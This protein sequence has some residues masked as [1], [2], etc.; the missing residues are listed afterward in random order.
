M[1]IEKPI[2]S[3]L[4]VGLLI[5]SLSV[6]KYVHDLTTWAQANG[7]TI[8]VTHLIVHA[9]VVTDT[10]A[11]RR[12]VF[13]MKR[14]GV[15]AA[16]FQSLASL[17]YKIVVRLEQLRLKQNSRYSNHMQMFDLSELVPTTIR[18]VPQV[19]KSG[20]VYRFSSADVGQVRKLGLDLLV[21]CGSGILRGDILKAARLGILSFHHA[22]NRINRGGPPGFWEVYFQ[23]DTTGFT[24]QQLTEELD[25]G[26][27]LMRGHFA[28]QPYYLLN[29]A[30]LFEK[31]NYYLT[32]LLKKIACNGALP[33][34]LESV[35]YSNVLLRLPRVNQS[36][37][38]IFKTCYHL[39]TK[40]LRQAL[41]V[42]RRWNV[43]Y[44]RSDW[45]DAVLS[46]GVK[47]K[48]L[49]N[50]FLADPFVMTMSGRD[51]C[52]VEDYEG[53]KGR[54][55]IAVYELGREGDVRVGTA[56]EE[57]FHLSFPFLFEYHGNI[58]MC[59]ETAEKREIRIYRSVQFPL[60]WKLEK[61]IMKN[62]SA[63]DTMLLE[64]DGKWWMFTNIDSTETG[65]HCCEL[66]IFSSDSPFGNWTPH[67]LNP[68]IVDAGRARNGGLL[69]QG[70]NV[71]R[72][73]QSQGFDRYGKSSSI[74]MI[75]LLTESAY[76]ELSVAE[77]TPT[78]DANC[79]GTHHLHSNGRITVF[80]FAKFSR[81]S[82]RS[83]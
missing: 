51:F 65:D 13:R 39:V 54:G 30:A 52:F 22:D 40:I 20:F 48:A 43:A 63:A 67:P 49:P 5:D 77:I 34:A 68:I 83:I 44:T 26:N 66:S 72:V 18:I 25:G 10:S 42:E 74:N 81:I 56:L 53:F 59:P 45:S 15:V 23:Q 11:V 29:Q 75:N 32:L 9:P 71:F 7:D 46:R 80:D 76:Q 70:P 50:H 36:V 16:L 69:K 38:Y 14:D 61:V 19:S 3:P 55:T 4:R 28:T 12:F 82:Q 47:L 2:G 62:V 31:S 78:F 64:K 21:R 27:V 24:I 58:Y 79:V 17:S 73:S 57:D 35:P 6:S 41:H 8:S 37:L 60:E 33:K 1:E